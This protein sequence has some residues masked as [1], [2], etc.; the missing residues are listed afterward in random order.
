MDGAVED[1]GGFSFYGFVGAACEV[2][3][4]DFVGALV[5]PGGGDVEGLLGADVPD[6]A[7]GVAVDP[8][9]AFGERAGVQEGIGDLF[10]RERGAIEA[11]AGAGGGLVVLARGVCH[12]E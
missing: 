1:G 9:E 6:A 3:D 12:G 11:G 7:Q 4:D 8:D 2:E 10:D 5:E